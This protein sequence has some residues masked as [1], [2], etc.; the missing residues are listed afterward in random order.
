MSCHWLFNANRYLL[1]LSGNS[2]TCHRL[3]AMILPLEIDDNT[4]PGVIKLIAAEK[5]AGL[6]KISFFFVWKCF[7]NDKVSDEMNY[8]KRHKWRFYVSL[9]FSSLI[10]IV[11]RLPLCNINVFVTTFTILLALFV[12]TIYINFC[13]VKM[14]DYDTGNLV[15]N[16]TKN[17]LFN[18]NIFV[19]FSV[20]WRKS[21]V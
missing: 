21:R 2:D 20:V 1:V 6:D 9:K 19:C 5:D 4:S 15:L 7:E 3:L 16:G 14:L 11:F 12:V 18:A 17:C 10:F 8:P 13:Y